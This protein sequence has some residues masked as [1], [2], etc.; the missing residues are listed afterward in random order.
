MTEHPWHSVSKERRRRVVGLLL[1]LSLVIGGCSFRH[2]ELGL[3]AGSEEDR[4]V[5][6]DSPGAVAYQVEIGDLDRQ[7]QRLSAA[8]KEIS[9]AIRLQNRSPP[10][11]TG[12]SRRAEDDVERF[13]AVLRSAGFYDGR[14]S[15]ALREADNLLAEA[16][17]AE[18]RA[19]APLRPV[20]V[21][22]RIKTGPAYLLAGA[23]LRVIGPDRTEQRPMDQR[24]LAKAG[25]VPGM[26]AE[27]EPLLQAE[28]RLVDGF[29]ADGYPLAKAGDRQ[30]T[31]DTVNKTLSLTYAVVTGTKAR[32]GPVT[33][34]G[35]VK[36]DSDFIS[37]YRSWRDG[38]QFSPEEIA[39]TRRLLAQS[40]LFNSASVDLAGPVNDRGEIPIAIQVSERDHR[41]VGGGI[42]FSTADGIGANGIWEHRNLFGAGERLRVRLAASQL[43]QGL[44]AGFNK[45][46]FLRHDQA[47]V[48]DGQGKQYNTAAYEGQLADSFAGIERRFAEF[49]SATVGLTAEYSALT[50]ADSPDENFYLGGMRGTIRRDSTSDPLDPTSGSRLELTVSPLTSLG[51][52]SGSFLSA[53][54]SGS[55]YVPF[56]QA[57]RYVL[58]GRA[59]LAGI[60]GE[61]R[62][63]LPAHK[64]YY[65]GGGGSVRGYGYQKIGPLDDN[66]DPL[67]GR[68]VFETGLEFRARVFEQVGVVPF[69]EGGN[70]FEV[71]QP[72]S[73][74]LQWAAGIGLRYY[75]AIGPLRLDF[76]VPLDKRES[77]DDDF[78][79]YLSI[80]QAF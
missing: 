32:F 19:D 43:Q 7:E 68:S 62:S 45:P 9:T 27:A 71:S 67:G 26:R 29:R 61:E 58:A 48:V 11:L 47:L 39:R 18:T 44:E 55:G 56:D 38:D 41:T 69:V 33:V 10:T 5:A 25:L 73:L 17:P 70:V 72:D 23:E 74:D 50:G 63:A 13:G 79:I 16:A 2:P 30:A 37:G 28:G 53:A 75:T 8:L 20:V 12:L 64:R 6:S 49:W 60:W 31:A 24:E 42:E 21:E 46:R 4:A 14:V 52:A 54:L 80:G 76:A 1:V 35:A 78:Q 59:R 15:Y 66:N 34:S 40:N 57:G 3:G 22:Y 36:V 65:S 77:V 51:G